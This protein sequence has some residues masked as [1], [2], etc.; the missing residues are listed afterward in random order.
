LIV[1][2]L[3]GAAIVGA[4]LYL[5]VSSFPAHEFW[6]NQIGVG[7]SGPPAATIALAGGST[8]FLATIGGWLG[9]Q[10]VPTT[11]KRRFRARDF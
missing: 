5:G 2:M 4:Q 1:G 10:L 6:L 8:F 9:G 11:V 7:T 3:A